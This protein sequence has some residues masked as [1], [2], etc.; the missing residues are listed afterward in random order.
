MST[1]R[2][3]QIAEM[4]F[5]E[6]ASVKRQV[7]WWLRLTSSGWNLPQTTLEQR[8]HMRRSQLASWIILGLLV[9]DVVLLPAGIDDLGTLGAIIVV[10]L[11]LLAAAFLNRL[12]YVT[13]AGILIISLLCGGVLTSV[14]IQ[15]GG[16]A[17]D[18]LPAY[19]LLAITVIVAAS[20]L[21]R[22]SAFIVA[23]LN[24][25][26]IFLDFW[27]QPHAGNLQQELQSYPSF[28]AGAL[29]LLAR[30]VALQIVLATV[31]YLWVLGTNTALARADRA[32]ELAALEHALA[33]QRFELESGVQDI[34]EALVHVA[35]GK[36]AVRVPVSQEH[37]LWQ[38]ASAI[39]NLLNR[40]QRA[41]LKEHE[42]Y[43]TREEIDR[44]VAVLEDAQAGR[45]AFWPA[46]SGTPVD[47]L[48]ECLTGARH[49]AN[50]LPSQTDQLSSLPAQY[51]A[52][53]DEH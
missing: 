30:P 46:P 23:A 32:E 19:D 42:F 26:L 52:K 31:A 22:W 28:L 9:A 44:L 10:G 1:L 6:S 50:P 18:A 20:V 12:G 5:R 11:G 13:W 17:L 49:R 39:N 41:S 24:T 14:L 3:E 36:L 2:R 21:P 38:I 40:L 33:D 37:L 43:R 4:R 34:L 7:R 53:K 25:G 47:L 51:A 29:A 48:I 45:P 27:L 35:N 8:E 15:S 16:L